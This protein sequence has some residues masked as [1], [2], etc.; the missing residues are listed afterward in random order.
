MSKPD[1]WLTL[2][3]ALWDE[4]VGIHVRSQFYDVDGFLAGRIALEG[5]EREEVGPVEGRDLVHL[6]CHFGL[7]TLSWA[8]LGAR[9]SGLDFSA[10]AIDAA[11]D[12]AR[13]LGIDARF[14]VGN[15]YDAPSLLGQRYDVV[16][17]GLG[18]I[19]WLP[20]IGRWASVCASLVRPGGF[21]YLAEFHPVAGI[22]S[23]DAL[24][25]VN[26]Y[27]PKPEG[28]A[29]DEPGTYADMSAKTVNN[30]SVEWNH[31][32]GDV[33][34]ALLDAGLRLEFLHE[35]DYTLYPRWPFLVKEGHDA[36]RPPAGHPRLPLMYSLRASK[37]T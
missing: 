22:F 7:D 9:V 17:T 18:A 32:V 33:V 31:P 3:R 37:P 35:H 16:Y 23:D 2:N 29:Y 28:I 26:D 27:F 15:V 1:D 24:R 8:R 20:D 25:I 36:W 13:K 21:L 19:N 4:R 5:F 14:E 30:R 10:P 34:T 11:R 6:Q 12:L